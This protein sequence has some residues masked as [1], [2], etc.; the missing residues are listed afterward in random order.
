MSTNNGFG[1]LY[2][3]AARNRASIE[4]LDQGGTRRDLRVTLHRDLSFSVFR[5]PEAFES[6]SANRVDDDKFVAC[7]TLHTI[8]AIEERIAARAL[9]FVVLQGCIGRPECFRSFCLVET[10]CSQ[11]L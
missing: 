6:P 8:L 3:S 1:F 4:V 5:L 9:I 7:E 10:D 2:S 11:P